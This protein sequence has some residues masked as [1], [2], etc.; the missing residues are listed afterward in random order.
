MSQGIR[1]KTIWITGA[2][3]GIGRSLTLRLVEQNNFV[4][5]SSRRL[6]ALTELQNIAPS[7][8]RVLDCDLSDDAV[9]PGVTRRLADFTDHLDMVIACAGTCEYDDDL[10]LDVTMYR[11]VFDGNFFALVN[12]LKCAQPLL[13][14]SRSPVFAALGS[15][16]SVVPFPRA[17]AYGSS[18]A[19]VAYF[20][21]SVRADTSLTPLR[22]V[23]IRPG[24][25]DTRLTQ[26]ND[27]DMPFLMTPE[28]AAE[29][30][31]QGLCGV[32][33]TVDF[34]KRLSWPL[35]FLGFFSS[36]WFRFCVPQMTRIRTLR[37]N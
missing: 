36:I 26:R 22:V 28:Q 11:R 24:F 14:A 7:R 27:F 29:R 13:A 34:P 8:L 16:S 18:K 32:G 25:V 6:D 23:H 19:A 31:E 9:M 17:E 3:S 33:H 1:D 30:I 15:L 4:I 20:L 21:E 35:R 37:K 2:S 5:A 10:Q 12:T